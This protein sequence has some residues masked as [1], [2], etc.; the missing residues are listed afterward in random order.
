MQPLAQPPKWEDHLHHPPHPDQL[1]CG[2]AHLRRL[3]PPYHTFP[4]NDRLIVTLED[5]Q[6][7]SHLHRFLN[8]NMNSAFFPTKRRYWDT[9]RYALT[10]WL[11]HH[12]LPATL[13]QHA[14]AFLTTQWAKH[15]H[16]LRHEDRFTAR[17]LKQ[18]QEFL[19]DN[20]V[21]HH[22]DHELQHLRIFCPRVY[23]R[24]CLATWQSPELFQPLPDDTDETIPHI[25]Q[26]SFPANLRK[27]YKWGFLTNFNMP[28]GVV[29]LKAKKQWK[30]GRAIISYYKSHYGPLLRSSTL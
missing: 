24:G 13:V 20:V 30:K 17:S 10:K 29:H 2:C 22:A 19:G 4:T 9:F 26:H 14:E 3:L 25:I 5:L 21:L 16:H 18:L 23:F 15:Q 8:A 11:K 28:Y 27:K 1:P 6:L 7:P 12:G